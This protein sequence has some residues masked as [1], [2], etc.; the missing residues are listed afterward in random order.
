[1][2][3]KKGKKAERGRERGKESARGRGKKRKTLN[4]VETIT[5][6]GPT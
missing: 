5:T 6:P 3:G 4:Q 2:K 1:M